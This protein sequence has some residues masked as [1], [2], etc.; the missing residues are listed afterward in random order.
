MIRLVGKLGDLGVSRD[1]RVLWGFKLRYWVLG[2]VVEE[3]SGVLGFLRE[4]WVVF[5]FGILW[6][7]WFAELVL[8]EL[9]WVL[10]GLWVWFLVVCVG[11]LF[12][13]FLWVRFAFCL[14]LDL[15]F[16]WWVCFRLFVV[17]IVWVLISVCVRLF[18]GFSGF[19]LVLPYGWC[20]L[21]TC[22][23]LLVVY[24]YYFGFMNVYW[25]A[26]C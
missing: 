17:W 20:D 2:Y 7:I 23:S 8:W 3:N 26:W 5:G 14:L 9:I 25:F 19:D 13:G 24:G 16:L 6:V 15:G 22:I 11:V 10:A 18:V 21:L 4:F 12:C 1:F